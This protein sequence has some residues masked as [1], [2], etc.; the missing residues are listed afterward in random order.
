MRRLAFLASVAL[1]AVSCGGGNEGGAAKPAG[2]TAGVG[3]ATTTSNPTTTVG[4]ANVDT[5][6]SSTTTVSEPTGLHIAS[7]DLGSILVDGDGFTLYVFMSDTSATSRCVSACIDVWPPVGPDGVGTPGAGVDA[8][9]VGEIIRPDGSKQATYA[10]KPLYR[11]A[12]D[13]APALITGHGIDNAWH[14]IGANG[15]SLGA[16][17]EDDYGGTDY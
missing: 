8:S 7:T 11:Y 14:V 3:Q 17:A 2:S 5:A 16:P 4:D 6:P 10:G 15:V 13:T 12:G 9:R 1:M